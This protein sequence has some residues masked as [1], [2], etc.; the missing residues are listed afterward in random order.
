MLRYLAIGLAEAV[1]LVAA[2]DLG[3]SMATPPPQ[4]PIA[5]TQQFAPARFTTTQPCWVTGDM[6]GDANPSDVAR[7]LCG[8]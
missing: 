7:G 2:F 5:V 8:R 3:R 6:V 1:L 4:P